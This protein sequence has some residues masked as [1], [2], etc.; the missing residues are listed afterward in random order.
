MEDDKFEVH[1]E[2]PPENV[3]IN[4]PFSVDVLLMILLSYVILETGTV[5]MNGVLV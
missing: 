3:K 2:I 5:P 1:T 4:E